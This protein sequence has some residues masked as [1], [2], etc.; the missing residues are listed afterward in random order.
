MPNSDKVYYFISKVYYFI[1]N[2]LIKTKNF[3]ELEI[4]QD[5]AVFL[6][7]AEIWE[8]LENKN[9]HYVFSGAVLQTKVYLVLRYI[10]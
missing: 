9:R 5:A 8:Q 3:L 7:Y 1:S 10:F 4:L 6:R 2:M